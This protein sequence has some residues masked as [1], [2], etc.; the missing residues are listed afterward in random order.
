MSQKANENPNARA[1]VTSKQQR[2]D[3]PI[4]GLS[5]DDDVGVKPPEGP[6]QTGAPEK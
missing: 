1:R 3:P 5:P 4:T 2:Q 6:G